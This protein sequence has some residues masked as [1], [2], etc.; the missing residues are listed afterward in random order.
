MTW[1]IRTVIALVLAM[2]AQ[3]AASQPRAA[4]GQGGGMRE[5]SWSPDGRQIAVSRVDRIW[6]MAADGRGARPLTPDS[7]TPA[8]VE[9]EPAWS[10]DGRLLAFAADAGEGFDL[11]VAASTGGPTRR[12]TSMPGDERWPSWTPDGRLVFAHRDDTQADLYITAAPVLTPAAHIDVVRLTDSIDIESHPRVSPDGRRVAFV[13]DR[14]SEDG[15]L[16]VWVAALPAERP[17]TGERRPQPWRPVR[18]TRVRGAEA[19]PAWSPSNDRLAYLAVREGVVSVW[20]SSVEPLPR[21]DGQVARARPA[22]P[23][24]LVSRYGGA[25]AWKPDGRTIL[26]ARLPADDPAYNGNPSRDGSEPPPLFGADEAFNLYGVSAPALADEGG[27]Y[28]EPDAAVGTGQWLTAFDRVWDTLRR[29]YYRSGASAGEWE[30]LRTT[31]RPRAAAARDA[32]A[33]ES[34]VDEM[35]ARQPLIKP[36]VTSGRA[37]VASGHPLASQ[38]GASILERGGNI[39]DAAIAVSFALGVVEPDASG[40][41][42][43]GMAVLF[44]KGMNEPTVID[45][46]DQTPIHAT[47]DN[48]AIMREGRLVGDG[49]ASVNIPGVVAGLQLLYDKYGSRRVKWAELVE[50]AI[51]YAEEGFVLDESLPTTI[52]E[53]RRFLEKYPEARRIY[54]PEGAVP[55]AGT[56]FVN[57]DYGATLRAIAE[58]GGSVFY[59]GRIARAIAADMRANGGILGYD[60]LAQY[61][62]IERTPLSGRYRDHV[63]FTASPP[64]SSGLS[65]LETFQILDH[66]RPGPRA[67]IATDA[68]YFHHLVEAWKVRDPVRRVA[69]PERWA[70][71]LGP[72]LDPAHAKELFA[73]IDPARASRF[74]AGPGAEEGPPTAPVERIGRGTTGFAIADTD[75]NMIAVTQTL[76]TWGGNFYVSKDLGFLYNNHLRS[77]RTVSGAYGQLVPLMRS[78]STS[79]PTLVFK[80][81]DG[82]RVPRLTVAV[83]GNAWITASVY[84]MV[85]SVIDAGMTAQRAIEAPRFLVGRDPLDPLGTA[86]RVQIEDRIPAAVLEELDRR[87]HRFEKIGRKGEVRYGYA[88]LVVVD[89][90]GGVVEGG[91]EPR[92]SHQAAAA[93]ASSTQAGRE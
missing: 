79:N 59:R 86:A 65:L 40:I 7:G 35:V 89:P 75:G 13:S 82:A 12:I 56:R 48:P 58:E 41:G 3:R 4:S 66:F 45:Y 6:V 76:S 85:A 39:V 9:R 55:R 62:A 27:R 17:G 37:V 81:E 71:D 47:I 83:A 88:S 28:I 57:R 14:D 63:L 36:P 42:G 21:D 29:L 53:G 11:E 2:L 32:A 90:R 24:V 91:S 52:A 70:V 51:R 23:A 87:G 22:A 73:R 72:H 80:D 33:F 46:K 16:D 38:A 34:V 77:S 93:G 67:T 20:V 43:D 74:P 84:S 49:P 18:V 30:V 26:I 54:L 78:S 8:R 15:E 61:R 31:Y 5:P 50:P 10:P 68:D 64:V 44:L 60:D 19:F 25:P 92:R 69:D 1:P